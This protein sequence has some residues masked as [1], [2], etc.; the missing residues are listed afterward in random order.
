MID[1]CAHKHTTDCAPVVW[2]CTAQRSRCRRCCH[3]SGRWPKL[4]CCLCSPL[5]APRYHRTCRRVG[6]TC[7]FIIPFYLNHELLFAR[8]HFTHLEMVVGGVWTLPCTVLQAFVVNKL[9]N[10]FRISRCG[11]FPRMQVSSWGFKCYIFA[12]VKPGSALVLC[13]DLWCHLPRVA[14]N[15]IN[16]DKEPEER[17]NI[18]RSTVFTPSDQHIHL[19][20]EYVFDR[21]EIHSSVAPMQCNVCLYTITKFH[22]CKLC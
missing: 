14:S 20:W 17:A 22:K 18:H 10:I 1:A 11:K 9:C 2:P 19:I 16:P 12:R 5:A 6:Q 7:E 3:Q 8:S 15:Y 13:R 21:I 4:C